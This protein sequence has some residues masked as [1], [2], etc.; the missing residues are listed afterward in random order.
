MAL[1]VPVDIVKSICEEIKKK[2]KVERGWLGVSIAEDEEGKVEILNIEKDGPAE[3]AK[4]KKGDIILEFEGKEVTSTQMLAAEIR[5]RKPGSNVNLKIDR[6]G[7]VENIKV[8]LGEYPEKE[9]RKELKLKFPQLFPPTP[10]IPPQPPTVK[11]FPR[12]WEMRKYIGVYLEELNRELSA[13]F[14]VKEGKGLL[15]SKITEG[16]PAEKAGLKVGDVII[17]A[18]GKRVESVR[19]LSGLIQDKA[20]GDKIKIEFLRDKK[21][22]TVE[23]EIEEEERSGYFDFSQ[24]WEEYVESWDKYKGDFQKELKKWQDRYGEEYKNNFKKLNK[25][26]EKI[27]EE[28]AEK[29]KE[30]TKKLK[31][32]LKKVKA[33]KV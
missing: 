22:K 16:G 31:Y 11:I 25:E 15:I 13:Y 24:N 18:E 9:I 27:S 28:M 20:K 14:G 23:V 3:L 12:T 4:L 19:R 5:R 30:A 17:R 2:G 21:V 7:K 8:R 29:S 10:P 1:A 26:L 32:T 6:Q 33:V